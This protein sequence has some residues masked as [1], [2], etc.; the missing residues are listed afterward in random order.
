MPLIYRNE[1]TNYL[2]RLGPIRMQRA[3][4]SF[5]VVLVISLFLDF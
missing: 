1:W 4:T 5:P 3:P 2:G